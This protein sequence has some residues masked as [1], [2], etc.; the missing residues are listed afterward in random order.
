MAFGVEGALEIF[1]QATLVERA[2]IALLATLA[3]AAVDPPFTPL[4]DQ[5]FAVS[6]ATELLNIVKSVQPAQILDEQMG[7][8]EELALVTWRQ[9]FVLEWLVR[10]NDDVVRKRRF[11]QG[12]LA[13][14]TTL[15]L[16]RTLGG[17]VRGLSIGAPD[18]ALHESTSAPDTDAVVIP[19]WVTLRGNTFLD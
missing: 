11:Q 18:Y 9:P 1:S 8:G 15:N 4:A 5:S 6:E 17:N 10:G 3:R 16:D 2:Q 19:V 12:L 13:I 14:G 7:L